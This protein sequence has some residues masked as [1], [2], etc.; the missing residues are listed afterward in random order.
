VEDSVATTNAAF[1]MIMCVY[2]CFESDLWESVDDFRWL[3]AVQSPNWSVLPSD[4]RIS[5]EGP[6]QLEPENGP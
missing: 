2:C 5:M 6:S 1:H 3:R 4:Q